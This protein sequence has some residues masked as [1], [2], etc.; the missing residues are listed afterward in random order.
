MKYL[1][2]ASEGVSK[3]PHTS[4]CTTSRI[5]LDLISTSDLKKFLVF[6]PIKQTSQVFSGK[7]VFGIPV[8]ICFDPS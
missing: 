8:N 3:G 1:F 7:D 6:L 4:E 5:D 2:P